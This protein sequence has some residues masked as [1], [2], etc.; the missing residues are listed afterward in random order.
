M[1]KKTTKIPVKLI[2][3]NLDHIAAIDN[4]S[5]RL[6]IL[7]RESLF[8]GGF[9]ALGHSTIVLI[10]C[11][12]VAV[13]ASSASDALDKAGAVAGIVGTSVSVAFLALIGFANA[14]SCWKLVQ[15][16]RRKSS[17]LSLLANEDDENLN[18]PANDENVL[19][20]AQQSKHT[21]DND[22][23]DEKLMDKEI[24]DRK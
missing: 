6:K 9:F 11:I 24:G 5:R 12:V 23:D 19:D 20:F 8:L 21:E 22:I 7:Q 14:Y 18:E 16:R 17:S 2:F 13:S 15:L 4:V 3:P 1:R 10:M